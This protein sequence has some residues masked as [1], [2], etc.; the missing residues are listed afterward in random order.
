MSCFWHRRSFL[1]G[2]VLLAIA[3]LLAV[4]VLLA[5]TLAWAFVRLTLAVL[6][7][8]LL[9]GVFFTRPF[10]LTATARPGDFAVRGCDFRVMDAFLR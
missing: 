2:G 4:L 6:L 10:G 9:D 8:G 7:L 3:F 1:A 5:F